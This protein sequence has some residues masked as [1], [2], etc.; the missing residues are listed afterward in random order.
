MV[1]DGDVFVPQLARRKGHVFDAVAAVGVLAVHVQ[2]A[3]NV[4]LGDELGQ[5]PCHGRL[6]LA[7]VFPQFGRDPGQIDAGV[8]LFLLGA[9]DAAGAAEDAVFVDLQAALHGQAANGDVVRL[10]AGEVL[11][12]GAV[13]LGG[14]HAQ[15]HLQARA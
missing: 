10:G 6:D 7:P 4:V 13:G 3:A 11:Q 14:H 15:V 1:G 9:A 2:V 12:G 8:H 5:A